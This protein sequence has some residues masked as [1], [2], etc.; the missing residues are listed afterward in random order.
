MGDF[1]RRLLLWSPRVL[2]FVVAAFFAAFA[3][4][5]AG[6]GP[7]AFLRH[8]T[9]ALVLLAVVAIAW[10]WPA[11]GGVAFVALFLWRW[12]QRPGLPHLK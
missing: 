4:D 10:R 8:L 12:R 3:L 1:G 5:A 11:V 6:E 9:P 2:G 7:A